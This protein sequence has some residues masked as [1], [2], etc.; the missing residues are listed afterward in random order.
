[1]NLSILL[2]LLNIASFAFAKIIVNSPL[3][4]WKAGTSV[5]ISWEPVGGDDLQYVDFHLMS[6]PS[7][8]LVL[9]RKIASAV[10]VQTVNYVSYIVPDDLSPDEI[11]TIR[12][13]G[14]D[15]FVQY[16]GFFKILGGSKRSN[17]TPASDKVTDE[18]SKD[19]SGEDIDTKPAKDKS[20]GKPISQSGTGSKNNHGLLVMMVFGALLI[21]A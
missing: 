9:V 18:S 5:K 13:T 17:G 15:T 19:E 21:F 4:A 11:Y 6:G 14:G 10:P 12:A 1:M 7:H 3:T 8:N 20:S 2:L 16:T